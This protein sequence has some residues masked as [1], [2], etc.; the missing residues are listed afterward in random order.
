MDSSVLG[1]L[2]VATADAAPSAGIA[3]RGL[4]DLSCGD[5]EKSLREP[6]FGKSI[7]GLET[8]D[9]LNAIGD[10]KADGDFRAFSADTIGKLFHLE[11]H[12]LD[13]TTAAKEV[14][15]R[16][17]RVLAFPIRKPSREDRTS[18]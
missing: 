17:S 4:T 3:P 8:W 7:P 9:S 5:G 16:G 15:R 2:D 6:G 13:G 10:E 11:I 18:S 1:M 12:D 14:K